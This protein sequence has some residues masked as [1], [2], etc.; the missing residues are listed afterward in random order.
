MT[1]LNKGLSVDDSS[2]TQLIG[3]T[4]RKYSWLN[5]LLI[6]TIVFSIGFSLLPPL[7]LE[8][9]V[10][11]LTSG[12]K[13]MFS[14][15]LGY[16][17][18]IAISGLLDAAKESLITAFGQKVT[19]Q[20]RSAMS[21]KIKRLP[22]SY[23]IEQEPG[24]T[25]SRFVNDVNTVDNLFMKSTGLG[26]LLLIITPMIFWMTRQFQKRMLKAQME[27]RVAVGRT[28]QQIPKTKSTDGSA[29]WSSSFGWFPV[30]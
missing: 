24:M 23:F 25:A 17:W 9:I 7:V 26:F 18:I 12:E 21:E 27:N 29:M 6:L 4:I 22:S 3:K 15:A 19:H 10:D 5:M 16:F 14:M 1:V 11:T 20:I 2:K 28:N 30:R 13:I 8:K